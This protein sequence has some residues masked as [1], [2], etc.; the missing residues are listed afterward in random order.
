MASGWAPCIKGGAGSHYSSAP[1]QTVYPIDTWRDPD[2]DG[3]YRLVLNDEY[4]SGPYEADPLYFTTGDNFAYESETAPT[5]FSDWHTDFMFP[6]RV[7][8]NDDWSYTGNKIVYQHYTESCHKDSSDVAYAITIRFRVGIYH[9]HSDTF[10]EWVHETYLFGSLRY[11]YS[12]SMGITAYHEEKDGDIWAGPVYI[13]MGTRSDGDPWFDTRGYLMSQNWFREHGYDDSLLNEIVDPNEADPDGPSGPGGGGGDHDPIGDIIPVPDVGP[14]NALS[15]KGLINYYRVTL[16][17]LSQLGGVL[18]SEGFLNAIH[19]WFSKPQDMIAGLML[20]P[21]SPPCL[22]ECKPTVG[23]QSFI[24]AE[25]SYLKI[26]SQ[27][28]IEVDMGSIVLNEYYGSALDY[29]PNTKIELHLPFLGT[30]ELDVDEVMGNTINL[31]YHIDC[32][33]GD[34]VAFVS[35]LNS[36]TQTYGVRYQFSGACGQQMPVTS[37]D[38]SS[39]INNTITLATTTLGAIMSGGASIPAEAAAG[40]V[41]AA[42]VNTVVNGKARI[43]KSGNLGASTGI[44]SVLRPYIVKTIPRQSLP[45]NYR[46]FEGYP[47]NFTAVLSSISGFT[48]V[49]SIHLSGID[50]TDAELKEI[51]TLLKTGVEL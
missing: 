37:A 1:L 12:V 20:I 41:A 47:A 11:N 21:V 17:E 25:M 32:Y 19:N 6:L 48:V 43:A 2:Q 7:K 30:R 18:Y 14:I 50:C 34:C 36:A 46:T 51:E 9:E 16:S 24:S 39:I 8:I 45:D 42:S 44:M 29:S 49:D 38:F 27:Q 23:G 31:K 3:K 28:Y 13:G 10:T 40:A 33:N 15:A 26:I 4:S 5:S 35:V 22:Y